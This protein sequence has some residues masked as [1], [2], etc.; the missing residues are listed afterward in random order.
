[1]NRN[2]SLRLF[3]DSENEG[4]KDTQ[5]IRRMICIPKKTKKNKAKVYYDLYSVSIH[6]KSNA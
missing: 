1:M 4:V 5:N 3:M 2:F 6:N